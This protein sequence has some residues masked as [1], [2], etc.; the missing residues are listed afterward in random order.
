[1]QPVTQRAYAAHRRAAAAALG[2]VFA[3]VVLP[4]AGP[5]ANA[6]PLPLNV[7]VPL[8]TEN[9]EGTFPG[10]AWNVT[11]ANASSGFDYWGSTTY[12]ASSGTGSGYAAQVGNRS[13]P[14]DIFTEDFEG[15]VAANW[16]FGPDTDTAGIY[17]NDYWGVSTY[18]NHTGNTS[19]WC[20]QF[21]N[22]DEL[23]MYGG[24]GGAQSNAA[25]HRYDSRSNSAASRAVNLSGF[26]SVQM[27]FWYYVDNELTYDYA[28]PAYFYGSWVYTGARIGNNSGV[29]SGWLNETVN[30]PVQATRVGF[31]FVSDDNVVTEGTYI[32]DVHLWGIRSDANRNTHS[33]DDDMNAT[34]TRAIDGTPYAYVR[35]D[36]RYWLATDSSADRL[37]GT[38]LSGGN[39][40]VAD[41]HSGSSGGWAS[42]SFQVPG[43]ATQVGFRFV[44]DG[45]G[46]AEGA[47][48]DDIRA[49]GVVYP[50]NCTAN[51][52]AIGGTEVLTSFLFTGRISNGLRP[53][54][55]AWDFGDGLSS[56]LQDVAHVFDNA[57]DY[58]AALTVR[59]SLGQ[60]CTATSPTVTVAHDLSSVSISSGSGGTLVEGA[61]ADL[62]GN[63]AQ[64]HPYSL[65]W[66]L[67]PPECGAL[68]AASGVSVSFNASTDAGGLSCTVTGAVGA[69]SGS[70]VITIT[71]DVTQISVSP[72]T[73]QVVEGKTLVLDATDRYGHGVSFTWSATCGRVSSDPGNSTVFSATTTG[74]AVC[75]VTAFSGFSS[76]T[77]V[78][79]VIH[80]TSV[81]TV[82]P[83]S[84]SIVEGETQA[85]AATDVYGHPFDAVWSVA[86]SEC[87]ALFP[88]SG[89][90]TTLT[91]AYDAGGLSCTLTL[92]YAGT[93]K[94]ITV[95]V[96][97]D[98]STAAISPEAPVAVE[99]G[100]IVF[101]FVDA[102]GHALPA[103]WSISPNTCGAL[104]AGSGANETLTLAPAAGGS[105]C[106]VSATANAVSRTVSVSVSNG[107]PALVVVTA[108]AATVSAGSTLTFTGVVK[109]ASNHTLSGLVVTWSSSCGNFTPA[110][111]PQT[112]LTA[113]RDG[114][115][116]S[117]TI[118]GTYAALSSQ[119][120]VAVDYAAPFKVTVSPANP[121]LS[122]GGSQEFSAVVT[123]ASGKLVP[124]APITWSASCGALSATQ[125]STVT[126]T[127][128]GDLGG[129]SC[130]V[131]ASTP[132]GGVNSQSASPVKTG[133]SLLI[134]LA[135]VGAVG[136]VGV[137]FL[138]QRRRRSEPSEEIAEST[139][140]AAG[141]PFV[142][143]ASPATPAASTP[144]TQ[145]PVGQRTGASELVVA[146]PPG[147]AQ[148]AAPSGGATPKPPSPPAPSRPLASA[149][150]KAP[151]A[152]AKPAA[153]KAPAAPAKPAAPKAP[154]APAKPA[155]PK[156][157][158][159]PAKP[160]AP[161]APAAPAKP[162]AP[163]NSAAPAASPPA[164]PI[165][166]PCPKCGS[167]VEVGW[168]ACP[169]CGLDLVWN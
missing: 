45:S 136:A 27:D 130:S 25:F 99:G 161:K 168:V 53:F 56:V 21:G 138:L 116:T 152:P 62:T 10:T 52:S 118:T 117:C 5:A 93:T 3:A 128:P 114:G 28:Y 40:S 58:A 153:P 135:V 1:M 162:A 120:T 77:A 149:S 122:A 44:S 68:S 50:L 146:V 165:T 22:N 92:A 144:A 63:D 75:T 142:P 24:S 2:V 129:S 35:V 7:D 133:M 79:T 33:Y 88:L 48:L 9:F 17:G 74:G 169:D 42:S 166:A 67:S 123:D 95:A 49:D 87:G 36:Y 155:A 71:H 54:A 83:A 104:A 125:G 82:T 103:A 132:Y 55:F 107:P 90:S 91:S 70:T 151:A 30:I 39:W 154:A 113:P 111:G 157:P 18:R 66:S 13:A 78:L 112:I 101:A 121:S 124:D 4:L 41:P 57:G 140:P 14:A 59:D 158:A 26:T 96:A 147:A 46:L 51:V 131:T 163:A 60:T 86:P 84:A 108:Q 100:A 106:V 156:V 134:P 8:F 34:M 119:A 102:H 61:A 137:L 167:T 72:A 110:S 65:N 11:D 37:E 64:G 12:R 145:A 150:S 160:A 81:I 20:A 73:A 143:G 43:N 89:P 141:Q 139:S 109:T 29:T 126:F 97:H 23:T 16:T 15:N 38:Y 31:F 85:F 164:A 98:M 47:Y 76:A 159:A 105:T 80:D 94:D 115:G 69:V 127:A 148:P 32:D 6:A 19:I